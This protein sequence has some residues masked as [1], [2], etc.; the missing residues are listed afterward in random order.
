M[1]LI[2]MK[3]IITLS[4]ILVVSLLYVPLQESALTPENTVILSN[5]TD[6]SFCT[7][8]SVLL[9]RVR[10]EWVTVET[11]AIPESVQDKN[12]IIIGELD[13]DYT[14]ELIK[15]MI[16]QE[17]ID[18]IQGNGQYT[19]L[20]KESPWEEGRIIYMCTGSDRLLT[21][22]AA[23]ELITSLEGEWAHP[24]FLSVSREEALE[25]IA[26]MQYI[27]E[28]DELSTESLGVDVDA[29][30]PSHVSREE[31]AED[32]EYL[33]YLFS[34]G[35]CGYGYFTTRGDF[36]EAKKNILRELETSPTWSPGDLSQV[37]RDNLTFIHDC[38]LKVGAHKYGDHQIFWCDTSLEVWKSAGEYYFTKDTTYKIVSINGEHPDEFMF[39]SL[40][41]EGDPIYRIGILSQS[42]PQPVV[43]TVSCDQ[44]QSQIE[45]QLYSSDFRYF[46]DDIFQEDIIGGI[47]V[48][49]IR[50]F[51]DHHAEYIDQFISAARKY[52][53][54]PCLIVDIRGNG[55]G[56]EEW[57]KKWVTRFT[58][59]KPSNNRYFTEFISK[60]TMMGRANY[61]EYLLDIYPDTTFYQVE[62]DKF[63]AQADF[64]EKY[65]MDPHWSGPYSEDVEVIPNDTTLIV[66]TNGNVASAAE[67]FLIYLQQ[68]E[69]V[70]LVGEN[71][72][73]ALVFGQM[74]LH[75]LPHSALSVNLPISLNIPLD[76]EL[77]EERGFFPDLWI[78]AEDA[79]NHAVAAVRKGTITTV[80]PLPESVLQKEFVPE[81]R[82]LLEGR[83]EAIIA[84]S[85]L[86]LFGIV[87]IFLN[88]KRTK[89]FFFI[90]GVCWAAA[91]VIILVF[92]SPVG[93]VYFIVGIMCIIVGTYKWRKET[94]EREE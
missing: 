90:A 17:E 69:N 25:F 2:E 50:S 29:K 80:Q 36:D 87:F 43:L 49:R 57:P 12:L 46:S 58:G 47:P 74:T 70:V 73:G 62:M 89:L 34:H 45:I 20:E 53:G 51:S 10:P 5:Q 88:R 7:D 21:K 15:N 60:T 82:S 48:V 31:A 39:P 64:F 26:Q 85:I 63:R 38:H 52:K 33:F 71:S 41:A 86:S 9:R 11:A 55:G 6:K 28:D 35:Y 72:W 59:E 44:E 40:N 8:F 56:N 3:G 22:K 75:Q 1:K 84:I 18:Y 30:S 76:L 78:P 37:I 19:I 54:E 81:K 77:R 23:E 14:G 79:L 65:S 67:G 92:V 61:F 16:T 91:G 42:S 32:V 83:R 66:V 4:V 93:Y 24:P 13:A 68:V 94:P 27:P